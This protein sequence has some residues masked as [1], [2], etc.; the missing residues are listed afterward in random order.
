MQNNP[1]DI[2]P[3]IY[4]LTHTNQV[5]QGK[6]LRTLGMKDQHKDNL[7]VS[8]RWHNFEC[9]DLQIVLLDTGLYKFLE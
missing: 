3:G 1:K 2:D 6:V 7:K 8:I 9:L 4:W 5:F